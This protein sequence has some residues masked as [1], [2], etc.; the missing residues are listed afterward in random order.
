MAEQQNRPAMMSEPRSF[1]FTLNRHYRV[2]SIERDP[3]DR[4]ALYF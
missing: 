4:C 3:D 1:S 2:T